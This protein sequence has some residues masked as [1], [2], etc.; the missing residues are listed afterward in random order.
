MPPIGSDADL[1]HDGDDV[2]DSH[3]L[4]AQVERNRRRPF[5]FQPPPT[6]VTDDHALVPAA[7]VAEFNQHH[8]ADIAKLA[9]ENQ[10]LHQG[11]NSHF[12]VFVWVVGLAAVAFVIWYNFVRESAGGMSDMLRAR[13]KSQGG[14]D[15][16]IRL[17][18][19][20]KKQ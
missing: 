3:Q 17:S 1:D 4:I 14:D 5:M 13:Q 11:H 9:A 16:E 6:Y 19:F 7:E 18:S 12:G 10:A 20:N 15:K 8:E 2:A